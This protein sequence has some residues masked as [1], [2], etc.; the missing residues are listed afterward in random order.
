MAEGDTTVVIIHHVH[1]YKRKQYEQWYESVVLPAIDRIVKK[2][3]ES[4][5]SF[6]TRW[7]KPALQV[8]RGCTYC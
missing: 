4:A 3:P 7:P 1:P 6:R 5:S 8:G 2:Q